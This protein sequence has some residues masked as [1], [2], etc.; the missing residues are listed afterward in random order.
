MLG[1]TRPAGHAR[2][3]H[4]RAGHAQEGHAWEGLRQARLGQTRLGKATLR[5][6]ER[7]LKTGHWSKL[8]EDLEQTFSVL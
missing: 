5:Q 8:E 7:S 2:A 6:F 4:A 1:Q 3:G